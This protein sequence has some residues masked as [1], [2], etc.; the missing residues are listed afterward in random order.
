ML[1]G[2]KNKVLIKTLS[3]VNFKLDSSNNLLK[4]DVQ[5][6]ELKVYISK[7]LFKKIKWIYIEVSEIK[8]Y[9]G[10]GSFK[11]I[12]DFLRENGFFKKFNIVVV[13]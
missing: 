13:L 10:Q 12:D 9:K 1:T 4:I 3:S 7:K 11:L 2:M 5:G 6:Y 8:M